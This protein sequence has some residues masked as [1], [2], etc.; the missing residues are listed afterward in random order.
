MVLRKE[1]SKQAAGE[2][3]LVLYMITRLDFGGSSEQVLLLADRIREHGFDSIIVTGRTRNPHVDLD[4]Y[5]E[6]TG[7]R[8][9]FI[10]ELRRGPDPLRDCRALLM[11][12]RLIKSMDPD[13]VHTNTSKAG[14]LGRIAAR[15]AGKRIVVHST[16][17]HL[18]YGYY[19]AILT[20]LIILAERM[21]APLADRIVL[22]TRRS[23]EEHVSRGIARWDRFTAISPGIDVSRYRPDPE[24]R[25]RFREALGIGEKAQVIG[26]AGR[27][28]RVKSPRTFIEAAAIVGD[29]LP[30]TVFLVTGDGEMEEEARELSGTRGLDGKIKFLGRS[31]NTQAFMKSIDLFVLTSVNEG[32]GIVLLEAMATGVPVIATAVGGVSEVL[33]GGKYGFLVRPEDPLSLARC[34]LSIL[35]NK[36]L[37]SK[38]AIAGEERAAM[39]SRERMVAEYTSLYHELLGNGSGGKK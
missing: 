6:R 1:Q 4:E 20:R 13:I 5:Q 31:E 36:D 24:E 23:I 30:E 9:I 10:D 29:R 17:G 14:I 19:N 27:L 21:T 38:L 22:L 12:C 39:F 26:W 11:L 2:H 28:T 3:K 8:I 25:K 15:L 32:L 34:M 35:K 7:V 18:F 33:D 37:S 16:H